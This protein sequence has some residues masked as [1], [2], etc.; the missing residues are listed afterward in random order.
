[1][2]KFKNLIQNFKDNDIMNLLDFLEEFIANKYFFLFRFRVE[3]R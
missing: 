3:V 2:E 1:M